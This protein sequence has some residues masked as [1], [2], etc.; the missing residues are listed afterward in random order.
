[1]ILETSTGHCQMLPEAPPRLHL[2]GPGAPNKA[3]Q[4]QYLIHR[5]DALYLTRAPH[6]H[7]QPPTYRTHI[8]GTRSSQ[9]VLNCK[10]RETLQ[11]PATSLVM[12]E[13]AAEGHHRVEGAAD[14]LLGELD[15]AAGQKSAVEER[16][17]V[18]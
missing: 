4:H 13:V 2:H 5:R 10:A 17:A 12:P 11:L 3:P 18:A 7:K 14:S 1:L 6:F 8:D 15:A 9:N 16:L